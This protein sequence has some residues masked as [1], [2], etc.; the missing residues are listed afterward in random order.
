MRKL[1]LLIFMFVTYAAQ[2]QVPEFDKMEM[3]YAQR[4]YKMV[5]RKSN[6]LLDNP[7]YDYSWVPK[8]YKSLSAFQLSANEIWLKRNPDAIREAKQLF[9][10]IKGASDGK[11]ILEG[12]MYEIA[13]LKKDL[14]TRMADHQREGEVDK[15]KEL[16]KVVAE[17]FDGSLPEIEQDINPISHK[18]PEKTEPKEFEFNQNDRDEMIAFAKEQIGTPYVWAGNT[19]SGFDCSGFTS[20]V[21]GAYHKDIPRRAIDQYE[22]SQ[23]VKRKNVQPGDLIFFEN[24]SGISH[25]GIVISQPDEPLTMIHA[26]T[27][28]GIVITN[29]EESSYWAPRLVG[30]GT[31]LER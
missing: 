14:V 29:V 2:A 13:A 20:Y 3:L 10:E 11:P 4:H 19:P 9:L 25:V 5:Y 22:A 8:F 7:E 24:G 27:S 15:F 21:M 26:S 30:F 31:Y 28:Q 23:K 17:L 6:A 1:G 12:H 16:Q 18:N